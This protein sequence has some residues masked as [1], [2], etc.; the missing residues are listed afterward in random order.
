MKDGEKDTG[1]VKLT[2]AERRLKMKK[3]RKEAKKLVEEE[4][5]VDAAEE[6]LHSEVLVHDLI[7]YCCQFYE[8]FTFCIWRSSV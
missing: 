7:G 4:A 1:M 2:K 8:T 6:K 5:K 3:N